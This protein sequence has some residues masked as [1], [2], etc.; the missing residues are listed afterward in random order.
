MYEKV[1]IVGNLGRD[2]EMRYTPSGKAVTNLNVATNRRWTNAEGQTQD[3]TT[4]FRVA[5]WGKQ[6][7]TCN[8][9]LSKGSQVLIEGDRIKARAYKNRDG[10]PAASLEVTA[11]RVRFLG[12]G[13]GEPTEAPAEEP[14][15]E[16]EAEIPF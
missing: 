13:R 10:E 2:P 4:W 16:D 1:I 9:Y 11:F 5:V 3:E 6:A 12:G 15:I 8:Q 7:E 14:P